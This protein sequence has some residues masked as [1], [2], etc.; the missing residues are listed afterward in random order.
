M[1]LGILCDVGPRLGVGHLMRCAALAEEFSRNGW[2]IEV[3]AD[4]ESVPLANERVL[5]AGISKAQVPTTTAEHLNWMAESKINAVLMDSYL[6]DSEVSTAISETVPL[7]TLID[8]S[9]RGQNACMYVDQNY[10]AEKHPLP[11]QIAG[12]ATGVP[13]LAGS[14]YAI[15]SDAIGS[16]RPRTPSTQESRPNILVALGGT[17]AVGLT[18]LLVEA[19][20]ISDASVTAN[21]VVTSDRIRSYEGRSS[22]GTQISFIPTSVDFARLMNE[23]SGVIFAAGSSIWEAACLGKPIAAVAVSDNQSDAY[24]RACKAELVYGLGD[25]TVAPVSSSEL[26]MKIHTFIEDSERRGRLAAA[27][28]ATVDGLGKS[29]IYGE[30]VAQCLDS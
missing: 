25:F 10:G 21:V 17:D 3:A 18:D 27:A 13:R 9:T 4:V 19:L 16:M 2:D 23:A 11:Q 1:R 29:R 20:S 24:R 8:G 6:L 28:F 22:N 26:A 5:S 12:S 30:F 14:N 7:L 15:I